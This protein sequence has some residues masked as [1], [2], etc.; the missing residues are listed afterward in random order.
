M[1]DPAAAPHRG[2]TICGAT[3][4]LIAA[5]PQEKMAG[6]NSRP[7]DDRNAS[8]GENERG[9]GCPRPLNSDVS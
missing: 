3:L 5:I 4:G 9:R 1:S 8:G 2:L 7:R 6:L